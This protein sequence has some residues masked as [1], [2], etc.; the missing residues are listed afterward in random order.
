M[1]KH[2][3][4]LFLMALLP[5]ASFAENIVIVPC[6]IDK[7]WGQAD[8]GSAFGG[9]SL[10][11]P[12]GVSTDMFY[13]A[14]PATLPN[15]A[16]S[17]PLTTA[18]IA[19][20]L[21]VTRV[22]GQT[23]EDIGSYKY[24]FTVD[25]TQRENFGDHNIIV[26]QNG[27]LNINKGK[28]VITGMSMSSWIYG[29]NPNQP[30][31]TSA[32]I[33]DINA[34]TENLITL[35]Y[36]T[37]ENGTYGTYEDVVNGQGGSYYVKATIADNAN[38]D[39]TTAKKQFFINPKT[40][41]AVAITEDAQT[42]T[43]GDPDASFTITLGDPTELEEDDNIENSFVVK[44]NAGDAG[45]PSAKGV[46]TVKVFPKNG[47][48]TI[49]TNDEAT[50]TILAKAIDATG[51]S[52][53]N[54]ASLPSKEYKAGAWTLTT[55]NTPAT[56]YTAG[57]EEVIGGTKQV[58]DLKTAEIPAELQVWDGNTRLAVTT[59]FTVAYESNI[60]AGTATLTITG[61]GNYETDATHKLTANF[62]ITTAPL[63]VSLTNSAQVVAYGDAWTTTVAITDADW[64]SNDDKTAFETA[65]ATDASLMPTAA[66]VGDENYD[67]ADKLTP[68]AHTVT[69]SGGT[70]PANYRFVYAT[71]N[72]V[73]VG[74]A[75]ITIAL[76]A[77]VTAVW[78]GENTATNVINAL[79]NAYTLTGAPAVSADELFVGGSKPIVISAAAEAA[80]NYKPGTYA[81]TFQSHGATLADAYKDN[82]SLAWDDAATNFEITK[83]TGLKITALNQ[84][85]AKVDDVTLSDFD[86]DATVTGRGVTYS[87]SGFAAGEDVENLSADL[88]AL[89]IALTSNDHL[90]ATGEYENDIIISNASSDYYDLAAAYVAGN[91]TVTG[92]GGALTLRFDAD[93]ADKIASA[94][95]NTGVTVTLGNKALTAKKWHAFVL[96]FETSAAELVAKLG[97]YVVVNT[98]QSSSIGANGVETVKFGLVMDEIPAGTPFLIKPA[99]DTNWNTNNFTG[100]TIVA[101]I[102]GT[103][104]TG[105]GAQFLGTYYADKS[106]RWGY[107]WETGEADPGYVYVENDNPANLSNPNAKSKFR[108]MDPTRETEGAWATPVN[109][110]KSL[111]PM[112][113]FLKLSE[114][115]TGARIFVEDFEN[116]TTSIKSLDADEINGLKVAEGW[117]TID[118][119]KLQSA[120][121]QKGIYINN[122][123]KIVVK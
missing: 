92:V 82:Y 25:K 60:N 101:A 84:V 95:G 22:A 5:L 17:N 104:A 16:T 80:E 38:Y 98:L 79:T 81:I 21:K 42:I 64:K 121:T 73:T 62:T 106:I 30:T 116:G 111:S 53:L 19:K 59:D 56:Y 89:N 74:K 122:G 58:G 29:Q 63:N 85:V 8:P 88:S 97:K 119:I 2:F 109:S 7:Y 9:K 24:L 46:Y 1:R 112:Q 31:Y 107:N 71:N 44:V 77:G 87:I 75:E 70:A 69:I 51:I 113:A 115:A 118:G 43:F 23:S 86:D 50:Y 36:S 100:K 10:S 61:A 94:D 15:D 66:I 6:V 65:V 123:K 72:T 76:K 41:S 91:L 103:T 93:A 18:D 99:G 102:A 48:Y 110:A 52:I 96:P 120:P 49:T 34:V 26:Q 32:T 39:G 11:N 108:W 47:N 78:D 114:N 4:L 28:A 33:G 14:S 12:N 105:T 54:M 37:E 57:D 35:T 67:E 68:G 90:L 3:L 55:V 20:C 117:Y 13:V 45:L 83:N 27:D 40:I